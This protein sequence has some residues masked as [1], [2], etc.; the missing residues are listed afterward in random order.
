MPAGPRS[1]VAVVRAAER[2]FRARRIDHVYVGGVAVLAFGEPRTTMDVDVIARYGSGDAD[3]LAQEFRRRGFRA[4]AEDLRDALSDR[5]HSTLEDTRSR[6][7]IDLA[8]ATRPAAEHAIADR[9]TVRWR[10]M[11]LPVAAPEHT[12]VMK[13]RYGSEQDLRD[14]LGI[15][16]RQRGRLD[17][18]RMRAF[19]RRQGAL[20]ALRDLEAKARTLGRR[21][22]R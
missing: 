17:L 21:G 13:L 14:A 5:T 18:R 11:S 15:L 22:K 7:R 16:V 19:A 6:Y 9:V 20:T 8:A 2:A 10:G 3:P 1:Y 12:V 4:S